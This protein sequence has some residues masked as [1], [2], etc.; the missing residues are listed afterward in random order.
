MPFIPDT[1]LS[2]VAESVIPI[3]SS[4]YTLFIILLFAVVTVLGLKYLSCK[5]PTKPEEEVNKLKDNDLEDELAEV[6]EKLNELISLH[7]VDNAK[8]D[9]RVDLLKLSIDNMAQHLKDMSER[10]ERHIEKDHK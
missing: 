1:S 8:R 6:S 10:L 5:F 7:S 2:K 9:G 3:G 4:N